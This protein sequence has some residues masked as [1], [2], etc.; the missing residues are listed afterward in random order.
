MKNGKI[1]EALE[2]LEILREIQ[3][4]GPSAGAYGRAVKNIKDYTNI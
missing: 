4:K 1:I 2:K 3:G